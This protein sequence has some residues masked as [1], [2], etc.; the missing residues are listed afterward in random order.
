MK[1]LLH[2]TRPEHGL[3]CAQWDMI[4]YLAARERQL[5]AHT[6]LVDGPSCVELIDL[7]K[8]AGFTRIHFRLDAKAKYDV[9]VVAGESFTP[10]IEARTMLVR[11]NGEVVRV[12]K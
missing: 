5:G 8:S 11:D 2:D 7:A 6:A 9:A 1:L 12:D 3:T 10:P 4:E